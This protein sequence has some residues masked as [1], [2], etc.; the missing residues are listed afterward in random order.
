MNYKIPNSFIILGY[1]KNDRVHI[2]KYDRVHREKMIGYTEKKMIG[3][4]HFRMYNQ[5]MINYHDS[6]TADMIMSCNQNFCLKKYVVGTSNLDL[7]AY[8]DLF[9]KLL[10]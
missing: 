3:Y 5:C 7:N 6:K 10:H 4:A 8:N 9:I 1:R 2:K